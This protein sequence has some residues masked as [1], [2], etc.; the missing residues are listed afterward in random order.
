MG[1]DL[2]WFSS[3]SSECLCVFSLHGA[4]YIVK[5][6]ATSFYLPFNELSLVGLALDLID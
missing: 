3:L 2:A 4:I 1:F 5:N 6:F